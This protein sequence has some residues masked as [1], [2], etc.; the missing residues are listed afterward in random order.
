MR[1]I[2]TRLEDELKIKE[3]YPKFG[4]RVLRFLDAC[5]KLGYDVGV[6]AGRR[7][8]EQQDRLYSQGR[9]E[10]G[11]IVTNARGTPPESFHI[12]GLAVDIVWKKDLDWTWNSTKWEDLAKLGEGFNLHNLGK[13]IGDWPHFESNFGYKL[14]DLQGIFI[15]GGL[16]AVWQ[17]LD[18][19]TKT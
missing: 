2:T 1:D 8:P 15:Q 6:F 10:P 5:D 3:L 19:N 17:K 14:G 4:L 16:G 11:K 18:Q 9:T 13:P 7:T 12:L